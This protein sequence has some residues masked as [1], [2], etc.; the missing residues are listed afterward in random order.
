MKATA[1]AKDKVRL[2]TVHHYAGDLFDVPFTKSGKHRFGLSALLAF[3]PGGSTVS[4]SIKLQYLFIAQRNKMPAATKAFVCKELFIDWLLGVPPILGTL[5]T[6]L[7]KAD[8]KIYTELV[9][10]L[11]S[12]QPAN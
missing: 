1:V 8:K 5:L 7:Y 2:E 3:I 10:K 12:V 9:E 4:L 11:Q 6:W